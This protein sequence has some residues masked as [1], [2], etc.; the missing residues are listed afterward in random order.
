M[1][2]PK[3]EDFIEITSI[4]A[5]RNNKNFWRLWKTGERQDDD[6]GQDHGRMELT[7]LFGMVIEERTRSVFYLPKLVAAWDFL[8]T[9]ATF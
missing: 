1:E 3:T 6:S 4:L 2:L 8:Q 5:T 7:V 9:P